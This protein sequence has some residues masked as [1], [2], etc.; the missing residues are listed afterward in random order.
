MEGFVVSIEMFLIDEHGDAPGEHGDVPGDGHQQGDDGGDHQVGDDGHQQE[1]MM[2]A[3]RLVIVDTSRKGMVVSGYHLLD[4]MPK[5]K[6]TNK[7]YANKY[8]LSRP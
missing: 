5:Q 7:F 3:N 8:I 4:P 6:E 2:V 1:L